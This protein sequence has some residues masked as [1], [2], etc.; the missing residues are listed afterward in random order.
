MTGFVLQGHIMISLLAQL[1]SHPENIRPVICVALHTS[2]FTD[3]PDVIMFTLIS[4]EL[5]N[6]IL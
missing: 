5:D 6:S 4:S 1:R 3:N 2:S